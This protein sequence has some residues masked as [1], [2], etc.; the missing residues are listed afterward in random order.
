M[1][2]L[3]PSKAAT[4]MNCPA[5]VRMSKM[6]PKDEGSEWAREG[7]DAHA[8]A[9][10]KIKLLSGPVAPG[11]AQRVA[12]LVEKYGTEMEEHI[13]GFVEYVHARSWFV[14]DDAIVLTEQ[15]VTAREGVRG[16]AD[17][18]IIRPSL[19]TL[20]V[21]DLKYGAGVPVPVEGNEQAMIYA[22]GALRTFSLIHDIDYV[23]WTITQ[24]RGNNGEGY[25]GSDGMSAD[26][27]ESWGED[28]DRAV[29]DTEDPQAP[30]V[31]SGKACR[32]CPARGVCIPRLVDLARGVDVGAD[33]DLLTPERLG[34]IWPGVQGIRQWCGDVGK[35]AFAQAH[36]S[37][38]LPGHKIVRTPGHRQ[39]VDVD[40]LVKAF[41]AAGF[42]RDDVVRFQPETLGHLEK[43]AGGKKRFEELAGHVVG[44]KADSTKLVRDDDARPGTDHHDWAAQV[45]DDE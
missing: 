23:V 1:T 32:W 29:A 38:G 7:T 22:L 40:G 16:T 28:L 39:I 19:K 37:E 11:L 31:P 15:R 10:A 41:T 6:A 24:P 30:F 45:F 36:S 4:W 21:I 35:A 17:V 26:D 43:L 34:A 8:M 25:L 44:R 13:D 5:S 42:E 12:A 27:L 2:N 9:E 18:V 33:P 20:E 3:S 14:D